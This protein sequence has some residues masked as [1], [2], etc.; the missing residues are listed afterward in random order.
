[1]VILDL[2]TKYG[3]TLAL[4]GTAAWT[5]WQYAAGRRAETRRQQF[6]AYHEL[7]KQ[8]S[9]ATSPKRR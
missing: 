2:L 9:K 1:M 5:V 3:S 7:V 4:I 8:L 6:A